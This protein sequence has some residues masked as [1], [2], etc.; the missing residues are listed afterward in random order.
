MAGIVLAAMPAAV[1]GV[2]TTAGVT[3]AGMA[4]SG[5]VVSGLA[6]LASVALAVGATY[7]GWKAGEKMGESA[8]KNLKPEKPTL[9]NLIS[10][11]EKRD[12]TSDITME[13]AAEISEMLRKS[14]NRSIREGSLT[15]EQKESFLDYLVNLDMGDKNQNTMLNMINGNLAAELARTTQELDAT[16]VSE[17]DKKRAELQGKVEEVQATRVLKQLEKEDGRDAQAAEIG[18]LKE[19]QEKLLEKVG[20]QAATITQLNGE[21]THLRAAALAALSQRK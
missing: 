6:A 14:L 15:P 9:D 18:K 2:A 11:D 12:T 19:T 16:F 8:A 21:L 20:E 5:G 4:I 7:V 13:R 10:A 1:L 17:R 3:I